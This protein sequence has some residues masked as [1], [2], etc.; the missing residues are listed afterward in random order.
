MCAG[1][2]GGGQPAGEGG[3]HVCRHSTAISILT[4][5]RGGESN[6]GGLVWIEQNLARPRLIGAATAVAGPVIVHTLAWKH[7]P[8]FQRTHVPSVGIMRGRVALLPDC[9]FM[10]AD[11]FMR[12][13]LA[14]KSLVPP[15]RRR[16]FKHPHQ[17]RRRAA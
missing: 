3:A 11:L 7:A 5:M 13:D 8:R 17:S 2:F 6:R 12:A 10:W 14:R 9:S 16:S 15:S 4:I 1:T